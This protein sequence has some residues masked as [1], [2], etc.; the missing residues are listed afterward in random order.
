MITRIVGVE[1]FNGRAMLEHSKTNKKIRRKEPTLQYT[2]VMLAFSQVAAITPILCAHI[3][4][5]AAI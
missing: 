2:V 1:T 3:F 4:Y 5:Y